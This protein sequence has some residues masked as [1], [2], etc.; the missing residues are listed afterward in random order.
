MTLSTKV[1]QENRF[2]TIR[3]E[4]QLNYSFAIPLRKSL[5]EATMNSNLDRIY[6]DLEKVEFIGSSGIL[7]FVETIKTIFTIAPN[8][9]CIKKI[10]PEFLQIFKIYNLHFFEDRDI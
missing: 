8:K 4:G 3:L 6:L 1:F 9:L 2:L 10:Q 5:I 7:H